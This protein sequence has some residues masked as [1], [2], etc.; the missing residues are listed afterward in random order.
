MLLT[1]CLKP[2]E[3]RAEVTA[4]RD[5]LVTGFS[6][7]DYVIALSRLSAAGA[8]AARNPRARVAAPSG[9]AFSFSPFAPFL[10]A[11]DLFFPFSLL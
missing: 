9:K 1:E 5:A 4:S 10:H 8:G 2:V 11:P 7:P 6:A 3:G